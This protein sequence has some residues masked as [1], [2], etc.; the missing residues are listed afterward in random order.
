MIALLRPQPNAR[1]VGQPEPAARVAYG[2]LSA[3]RCHIRSTRLSLIV[4]PAWRSSAA[5][6]R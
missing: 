3:S 5:T 1:S 2:E 4:E 6:L